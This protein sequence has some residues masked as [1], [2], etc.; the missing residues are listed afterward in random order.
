M[1]KKIAIVGAGGLGR[2]TAC[3]LRAINDARPTWQ[4]IGF[5]DDM[6]PAG[7][8]NEYGRILGNTED[9]N[10][11]QE[12]LA[13][14]LAIA[15]PAVLERLAGQIDNPLIEFPNIIAPDAKFYD[16][17]SVEM[18]RGNLVGFGHVFSCHVTMGDFNLLSCG[19]LIGHDVT[20]GNYNVVA[21]GCKVSGAVRLGNGNFLGAGAVVL[22]CKALGNRVTLG[23]NSTLTRDALE[24]GTWAG[25][26][27]TLKKA[28]P[29]AA[30]A[31]EPAS[32]STPE[33]PATIWLSLAQT[34]SAEEEYVREAFASKWV[35]TVGP[36]V[37]AFEH[38][39]EEYLGGGHIVALASGTSALHLG[40]L[41]L[42]VRPGDEVICQSMTFAASANPI[43][44]LGATPVFVDSESS[45][46]NMSPELLEK[47]IADRIRQTGRTPRAIVPVD[48]YGMPADL[49]AILDVA[50]RYG[51]PVL[52]DA[53]EA[54]GSEY[55]GKKC[56]L[57]GT[58][59][60]FSFNGNKII[61][62]SGGG[63]L[64]CPDEESR[65]K[66]KFYATQARDAAPH[67]QHSHIGYNY[68]LSNVCAGIGRGQMRSLPAFL[69][70]RRALHAEY[71]RR[72][73]ERPGL[74]LLENPT[75]AY[76]SNFWLTCV[77]VDPARA[78]FDREELRLALQRHGVE[79]RPLWKPM[80]LQP[81]FNSCPYY[82]AGVSEDL[83]ERGLCLPSGANLSHGDQ[84]RILD[85]IFN[86]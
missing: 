65:N 13:V 63:A 74:T 39:L 84:Q 42:G 17:A 47:A 43:V 36:N 79:S 20:M 15:T 62:T 28:T 12:P 2:E 23:A 19:S 33:K 8:E 9:L 64:R 6:A 3:C 60:A 46:W 44:Y 38:E 24:A 83:F 26:P 35:T 5:F 32:P 70:K 40:L 57:F 56:G 21:N 18:G 7:T 10:R 49:D 22:P 81:V 80:H 54:L 30:S 77:L 82:G 37:D 78:G 86:L 53:A 34:G 16:S 4:F 72:L 48:L 1:K 31:S 50:G 76:A 67:Y 29:A 75:E 66:V 61:T 73:A 52:E 11:W 69:E 27:A 25:C 68:R 41:M 14:V 51:I 85:V 58:Y 55:K 71:R 45:T 59:S